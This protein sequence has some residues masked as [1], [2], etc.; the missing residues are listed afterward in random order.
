MKNITGETM[1]KA[2]EMLKNLTINQI[3]EAKELSYLKMSGNEQLIFQNQ[4]EY[5]INKKQSGAWAQMGRNFIEAMGSCKVRGYIA[6]DAFS[7]IKFW[8][9]VPDSHNWILCPE[10]LRATDWNTYDPEGE[11]TSIVG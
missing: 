1:N 9:N 4:C 8:K 5:T 11:A 10:D 7:D 3:K 6:R 2:Y